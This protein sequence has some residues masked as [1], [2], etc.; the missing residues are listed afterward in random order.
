LAEGSFVKGLILAGGSGTRLRPLTHSGAKQLVPVA[1]RPILFYVVDNL[2]QAG[3][4]EIAVI[5]SPETGDEIRKA[6][7]RGD[8]WN[9]NF[10]Y[11]IQE[12]PAGLAH[13]LYAAKSF[14]ADDAICMFLG[15]NLIGTKIQKM[16]DEFNRSPDVAA[17]ILLKEVDDPSH[18]GVAEI[19]KNDNVIGLEE[20]PKVPKSN[21]A[22]V[23]VY[24]FRTSIFQAIERIRPS[25][26]GELEITDAISKLIETGSKVRFDRVTSWW[27]DTGK[28]DDLILA[29]DT[30]LDSWIT[31]D[32]KGDVSSDSVIIGRVHI[33]AGATITDSVIRGPAVIGKNAQIRNSRVG[34]FTSIGDRVTISESVVNHSVI[35]E[36]ST[37]HDVPLLEDS[38]IGRRVSLS[39][40]K[41]MSLLLGDDCKAELT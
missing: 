40:G 30:V 2:V 17:S 26:R 9:A 18:F 27:L 1:N 35:M 25:S 39:R 21:L 12:K 31:R 24:L 38:L 20:K 7:G 41:V 4:T 33:D 13:A 19:D 10:T 32:I 16:V 8:A 22:V 34:P 29:N 11:I 23:G 36:D 15:D 3:I 28:K 5:V 14:L 37:I 6:L